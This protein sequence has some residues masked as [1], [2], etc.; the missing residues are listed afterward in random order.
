MLAN[1]INTG[2]QL[3]SA[4]STDFDDDTD[5]SIFRIDLATLL[6]AYD[7]D[8]PFFVETN[9]GDVLQ[10]P[11]HAEERLELLEFLALEAETALMIASQQKEKRVDAMLSQ[12]TPEAYLMAI[13]E[14]L[15]IPIDDS[16]STTSSMFMRINDK[17]QAIAKTLPNMQFPKPLFTTELTP[18]QWAK[19]AQINQQLADEYA[20]RRA[21]LLKRVDVTVQSFKWAKRVKDAPEL[22][23]KVD[24]VYL[25][26][27]SGMSSASSVDCK[28]VLW[29][30][31]ELASLEKTSN[32]TVRQHTQSIVNTAVVIGN[33]PDR[34]GR[35]NE[36]RL[37]VE[38]PFK[39]VCSL[40]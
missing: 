7:C 27:R 23:V 11:Q 13:L 10:H 31:R 6:K 25:D 26:R 1:K 20:L 9:F 15:D 24:Q 18:A 21:M 29:A 34:G 14:T 16:T 12:T 33:V 32:S 39:P 8:E 40:A 37:P 2:A 38:M 36:A 17:V 4:I 3:Q 19:L 30:P 5:G 22:V 28:D 35:P